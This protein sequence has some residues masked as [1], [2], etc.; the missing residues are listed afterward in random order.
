MRANRAD[1]RDLTT[2]TGDEYRDAMRER[3][4]TGEA[5][6]DSGRPSTELIRTVEAGE[7]AGSSLI[8]LGCGTGTNA[9][10]LARRG[11]RVKAIDLVDL[12]IQKARERARR[13]GVEV[14]FVVGDLTVADLGGPYDCVFDLGVYHGMRLRNLRGFLST[15]GQ[16]SRRGT[17]W[18]SL[19]G[20]ARE[21]LPDGPPVVREEEFRSELAPMFR[22]VRAREFRFD[23]RPDFQPLAWSILAER[24]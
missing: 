15:L 12:A 16:V 8:E 18:L 21:A 9:V 6:W 1:R 13:A 5:P 4:S 17:R 22:I 2:L 20:N 14:D 11:Y 19:A 10:E 3:Y 7:L 24:R 23:L